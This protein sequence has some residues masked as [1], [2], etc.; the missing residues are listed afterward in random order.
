MYISE[1]Q[2]RLMDS[3]GREG[4]ATYNR[5]L[6]LALYKG[7]NPKEMKDAYHLALWFEGAPDDVKQT[8]LDEFNEKNNDLRMCDNCGQFMAEGYLIDGHLHACSKECALKVS[9][10]SE[11]EFDEDVRKSVDEDNGDTFWTEW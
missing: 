9:G 10:E 6:G 5:A 8:F 11:E 1:I 2:K 7:A 3:I 4:Y